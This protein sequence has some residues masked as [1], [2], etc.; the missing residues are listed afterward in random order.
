V[1]QML[2]VQLTASEAALKEAQ[3]DA[4][5]VRLAAA[6]QLAAHQAALTDIKTQLDARNAELRRARAEAVSMGK[7]YEQQLQRFAREAE[8]GANDRGAV[9]DLVY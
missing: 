5:D 9:D 8:A 1:L 6:Q 4:A 7:S 2:Q 3:R